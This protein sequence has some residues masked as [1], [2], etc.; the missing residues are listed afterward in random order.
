MKRGDAD[1]FGKRAEEIAAE[2]L[3]T[4]GYTVRERN[5]RPQRTHLEVDI[6]CE[7]GDTI[8]FVEVKARAADAEDPAD[9]VDLAK[10]K[11]LSRA[12]DIYLRMLPFDFFYRFDIITVSG[13]ADNYT[14]DH[15][16]DAFL[17]PL[18]TVR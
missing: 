8:V 12:G 1:D 11:K 17:P 15:I 5:W 10:Q 6:I 2:Y 18:T 4:H 16:E 13:T 14:L 7:Q 9:A 3:L